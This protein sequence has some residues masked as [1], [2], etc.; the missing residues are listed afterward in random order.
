MGQ[1]FP[2]F[3]VKKKKAIFPDVL[4]AFRVYGSEDQVRAFPVPASGFLSRRILADKYL[5]CIQF[6]WPHFKD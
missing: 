3:L 1:E 2:D 4:V 5:P 6:S